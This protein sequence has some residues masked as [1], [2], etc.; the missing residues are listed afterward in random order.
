[1]KK[2]FAKIGLNS[3]VIHVTPLDEDLM[4]DSS[5]NLDERVGQEY[6]SRHGNWPP[7]MWIQCAKEPS[8]HVRGIAGIGSTWDEDNNVF[9]LPKPFDSWLKHLTT[10]TWKAPVDYPSVTT[11]TVGSETKDW[12]IFWDEAAQGWKATD[13][14]D[15]TEHTWNGS[16]WVS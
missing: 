4:K 5:G 13:P 6:L 2:Y 15:N 14:F 11:K 3:K 16:S 12:G 8:D 9:W 1:M 10:K 7:E